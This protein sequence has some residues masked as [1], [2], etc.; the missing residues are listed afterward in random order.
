[1]VSEDFIYDC[2]VLSLQ[3]C[4]KAEIHSGALW[5]IKPIDLMISREVKEKERKDSIRL[6]PNDLTPCSQPNNRMI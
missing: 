3:D 1:M 4:G 6:V 5:E 2:F